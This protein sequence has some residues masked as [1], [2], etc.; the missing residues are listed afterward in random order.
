MRTCTACTGAPIPGSEV[1]KFTEF[2]WC[3]KML[4]KHM[5]ND[6]GLQEVDERLEL[7]DVGILQAFEEEII[8]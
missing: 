8:G 6:V 2:L 5:T 4:P 7:L 3:V 1:A